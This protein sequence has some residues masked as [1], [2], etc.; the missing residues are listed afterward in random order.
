MAGAFYLVPQISFDAQISQI[1]GE[2][3]KQEI[4]C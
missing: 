2:L 4:S 3:G 1:S